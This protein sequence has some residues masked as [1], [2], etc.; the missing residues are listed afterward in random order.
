MK[1][2]CQDSFAPAVENPGRN[3][4]PQ[5]RQYVASGGF[6]AVH[7]SVL[8]DTDSGRAGVGGGRTALTRVIDLPQAARLA[9]FLLR[10]ATQTN[11]TNPPTQ[12]QCPDPG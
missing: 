11:N 8:H 6:E 1:Q 10:D 2:P 9:G 12:F 5:R 7:P 3:G 4:R